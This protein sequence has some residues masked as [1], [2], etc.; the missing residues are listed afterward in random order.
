MEWNKKEGG[1]HWPY[2]P[3][4]KKGW[5]ESQLTKRVYCYSKWM[6]ASRRFSS[7]GSI[8]LGPG[9]RTAR[10]VMGGS[11]GMVLWRLISMVLPRPFSCG[12]IDVLTVI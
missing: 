8:S 3:P 7:G 12:V 1:E 9:L 6:F 2:S 4:E 5:D 11:G 10:G